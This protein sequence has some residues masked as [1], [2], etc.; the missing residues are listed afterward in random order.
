TSAEVMQ[1]YFAQIEK[2]NPKVNAFITLNEK[3]LEDAKAIDA[4]IAKKENVGP[5][6]GV[7]IAIKDM[8]CTKGIRTTAGSKILNNFV[9]PFSATVV[10]RLESAGAI[11]IGKTN[12]D[13]FAMGSSSET[14]AFGI[15]RNPWNLDY[16][17]GGS[18]GG[19]AA[20]VA[21]G[22][23]SAAIGTDTGGS[24]RQ[25]SSFCGIVGVKPTYGRVSRY[26]IVAFASSLDQAG[27]MTRT[28]KDSALI[29]ESICGHDERDATSSAQPVPKWSEQ[30]NKSLKGMKV[31]LPKEYFSDAVTP[32]TRKAVEQAIAAV[33]AAGAETV[34]VSLPLTDMAVSIYYLVATSEASSNLARYDGVRFGHRADFSKKPAEDLAEFYCRTRGEGFGTEVKRR[35]IL[36]TYALSSGYYD[37][38][39]KKACQ[40]RRLMRQQ[41]MDAFSKCQILM[42][43]VCVSPAYKIG[44][45][46]SD[47]LKMYLNDIFTTSANLVGIPGMSVPAGFSNEGLPIGVQLLSAHFQ[48]QHLFNAGTV[49]EEALAIKELPN[50]LQ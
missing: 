26:G 40:V 32:E 10:N 45:R 11:N 39:Y 47:P 1:K 37:A 15:S 49:I 28:V 20:A 17:P 14:S 24:I 25:P 3:A 12:Q 33:K 22:M 18:S 30:I 44:E 48:E 9:P 21:A 38:Y 42:G 36:G 2:W 43:P 13:E 34:E 29:L 41:F 23:A 46:I 19:S 8:L 6:A 16:V 50:V 27:P 31:G 5:L 7:P 35:I 4:R